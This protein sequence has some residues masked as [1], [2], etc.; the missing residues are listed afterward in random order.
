MN[1]EYQVNDE[2]LLRVPKRQIELD[3]AKGIAILCMIAV[4]IQSSLS[5]NDVIHSNAGG[6]IELLGTLPAAPVF[7]FLLGT[8][9]VYSRNNSLKKSVERGLKIFALGYVLNILRTVIIFFPSLLSGEWVNQT[10]YMIK[11]LLTVDI[12]QFAGL[13]IICV[14]LIKKWGIGIYLVVAW[15]VLLGSINYMLLSFQTNHDVIGAITGLLWGSWEW[16]AFPLLTWMFYPL[17]GYCFGMLLKQAQSKNQ[18]YK[19][20]L[21][22][23]SIAF[24]VLTVVS[25]YFNIDSGLMSEVSYAHHTL[26]NN[27]LYTSFILVWISILFYTSTVLPEMVTRVLVRWSKN[28]NS[29]YI[30]HWVLIALLISVFGMNKFD[31]MPTIIAFLLICVASDFLAKYDQNRK[32]RRAS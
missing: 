26:Y 27:F 23:S 25:V 28:V 31:L 12:L 30:I 22:L 4:H 17:I 11:S 10:G 21:L 2:D 6:I 15:T 19:K 14:G 24:I 3:I 1:K 13:A 9:A 18:F 5:I 29:M 20:T 8:G 32:I 16:A 7:M